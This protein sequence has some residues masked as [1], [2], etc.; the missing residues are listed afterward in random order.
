MPFVEVDAR[1]SMPLLRKG[2][3]AVDEGELKIT[4]AGLDALERGPHHRLKPARHVLPGAIITT[5]AGVTTL[6]PE[7]MMRACSCAISPSQ[8][9][10]AVDEMVD[11]CCTAFERAIEHGVLKTAGSVTFAI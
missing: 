3:A 11:V 9:P 6:R 10:P 1:I 2:W 5:T 7:P 4:N 8:L